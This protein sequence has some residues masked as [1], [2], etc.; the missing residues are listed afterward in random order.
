LTEQVTA[1]PLA[2]KFCHEAEATRMRR[3][4]PG[5]WSGHATLGPG[6]RCGLATLGPGHGSGGSP[7]NGTVISSWEYAYDDVGN[8]TS[9]TDK[10]TLVTSYTYDDIYQLTAVNYPSGSDFGYEYDAVGNRTKMFEY[11]SSTITTTYTYDNADE[12]T[13]WTTSTVTMTFTYASDGCLVSK[14]DGTDTWAYEWDYERRLKAFKENSATLVEYGYNPTG[15]RRYSSDSTLGL[16]NYFYSGNHVLGDYSSNWTL[17]KSYILGPRVD[18]IIALIDRTSDPNVS[19]Y[20]TRDRLGSTREL[21]NSSETVNTRYAYDVWGSPTQT[22]FVG[23]VSSQYR[24]TGR[25]HDRT[26]GLY[27]YRARYYA[28]A[29]ARFVSR[30]P[31]YHGARGHVD[32][33]VYVASNPATL[34]DPSGLDYD[35]RAAVV[36]IGGGLLSPCWTRGEDC[37]RCCEYQQWAMEWA[38]NWTARYFTAAGVILD[39]L[40][41]YSLFY[42]LPTTVADAMEWAARQLA[43]QLM[44]DAGSNEDRFRYWAQLWGDYCRSKCP[45]EALPKTCPMDLA[46]GAPAAGCC[47][48]TNFTRGD[49]ARC[50][51]AGM[52]CEACEAACGRNNYPCNYTGDQ[53]SDPYGC[54]YWRLY[55]TVG[56]EASPNGPYYS[57][58]YYYWVGPVDKGYYADAYRE[59]H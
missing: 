24:F 19:Y 35:L 20:F 16:T 41:F 23:N 42:D 53:V 34:A 31:L 44:V 51:G 30:D 49:R 55:C 46:T 52:A 58:R 12:L 32:S 11:T 50:C 45:R 43:Y 57:G 33:Y 17:N 56:W 15:T 54:Y 25:E 4:G 47:D 59:C 6:H 7:P 14:S 2:E 39:F 38:G 26:S 5:Y 9:Q 18:E 8:V 13:Q 37:M 36:F 21:V 22:Q 27:Y 28:N 3:L 10:D 29:L 48:L 1:A 40:T